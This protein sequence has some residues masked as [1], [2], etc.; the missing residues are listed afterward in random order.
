[1]ERLAR[2]R[3]VVHEPGRRG[4][5][6]PA[7]L[8]DVG[9]VVEAAD[10]GPRSV[11]PDAL[12]DHGERVG[13]PR[14]A[15]QGGDA[16]LGEDVVGVEERQPGPA[17]PLEGQ[18]ARRRGARV[19][20]C[21]DDDHPRIGG[22]QPLEDRRRPVGRAVV[23]D[24]ALEGG[25]AVGEHRPEGALDRAGGVPAGNDDAQLGPGSVG[26][27]IDQ[28]GLLRR[29]RWASRIAAGPACRASRGASARS[30]TPPA[31]ASRRGAPGRR[32]TR[33]TAGSPS[34]S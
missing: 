3:R 21:A 19:L 7:G 13:R 32:P 2:R 33:P 10:P 17:G 4:D 34:R 28:G 31:A 18:V 8:P 24:D 25:L 29:G 6:L 11:V 12:A 15:H 27:A 30:A 26:R 9:D 23:H 5:G 16:A 20:G 1:M 14:R 22:G